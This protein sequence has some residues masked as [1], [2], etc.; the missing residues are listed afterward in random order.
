MERAASRALSNDV[1]G[2]NADFGEVIA[3]DPKNETA[4]LRR[5]GTLFQ[6][7]DF[8]GAITNCT[9]A[10]AV[11]NHPKAWE[12]RA[13]ARLRLKD[14]DGAL[15]DATKA[16]EADPSC[17]IPWVCRGTTRYRLGNLDGAIG[18]L[19]HALRLMTHP[20]DP[21]R[22]NAQQILDQVVETLRQARAAAAVGLGGGN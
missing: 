8:A 19:R 16:I 9:E 1:R 6:L 7:G 4:R 10:L 15:S 12:I 11:G 20:N 17:P 22:P 3:L 13:E 5:G 14:Y 2:A 18:D 21:R